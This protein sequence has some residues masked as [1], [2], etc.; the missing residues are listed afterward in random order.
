MLNIIH[1]TGLQ[2]HFQNIRNVTIY[3]AHVNIVY[4]W[5]ESL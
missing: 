2:P 1:L 4:P 3:L 5:P